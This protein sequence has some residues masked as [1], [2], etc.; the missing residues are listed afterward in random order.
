M[1]RY[2]AFTHWNGTSRFFRVWHPP[3]VRVPAT[4]LISE[5]TLLD[6]NWPFFEK[7][8]VICAS[9][10]AGFDGVWMGRPQRLVS[11]FRM[12]A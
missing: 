3:W 2:T 8:R 12:P 1:E 7:A 9:L 10:S 6:L 4:I 11:P 5:Q